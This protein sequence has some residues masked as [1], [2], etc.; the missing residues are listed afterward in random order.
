MSATMRTST[1]RARRV[2]AAESVAVADALH[3]GVDLHR[4]TGGPVRLRPP[5]GALVDGVAGGLG[6]DEVVVVPGGSCL[7]TFG[8]LSGTV[9]AEDVDQGT[10]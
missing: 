3:V 2:V 5:V 9:S 6:E 7:E 1:P 4:R 10:G 8:M